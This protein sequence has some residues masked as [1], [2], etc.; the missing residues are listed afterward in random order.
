[1]LQPTQKLK[2]L[3]MI[4]DSEKMEISLPTEKT[5]KTEKPLQSSVTEKIESL[6]N[7]ASLI[8]KLYAASPAVSTTAIQ[9][10]YLQQELIQAQQKNLHYEAH[11]TLSEDSKK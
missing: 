3:G 6:R 4:I 11:I 7:L 2:F 8:G 5:F 9:I 10:R 1:M